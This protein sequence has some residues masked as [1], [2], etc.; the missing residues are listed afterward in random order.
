M[1]EHALVAVDLPELAPVRPPAEDRL[2]LRPQTGVAGV[3]PYPSAVAGGVQ[4]VDRVLAPLMTRGTRALVALARVLLNQLLGLGV[5]ETTCNL[6]RRSTICHCCNSGHV[7]IRVVAV[8]EV[9]KSLSVKTMVVAAT[10]PL[11]CVGFRWKVDFWKKSA[12]LR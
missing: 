7:V 12:T 2:Y 8:L 4:E 1:R 9:L 3:D 10:K 11:I 5:T 6:C